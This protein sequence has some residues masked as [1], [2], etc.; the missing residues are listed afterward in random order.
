M[1]AYIREVEEGNLPESVLEVQIGLLI[2]CGE[3]SFAAFPS[4]YSYTLGLSGT[5]S[6]LNE[7]EFEILRDY[8]FLS[9]YHFS[10]ERNNFTG[11][12]SQS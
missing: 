5:L 7:H 3:L 11:L 9:S 4:L 6:Q 10:K 2:I 8:N 1:F 12:S